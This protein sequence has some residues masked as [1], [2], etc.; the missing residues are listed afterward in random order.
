MAPRVLVVEDELALQVILRDN[1]EFENYEVLLADTGERGLELASQGKADLILLDIMLPSMSGYDVC[2]K[3]RA[4]GFDIPIV[5]LTARNTALD[6]IAGLD[7]GA[8]DYIGKPFN[9]GELMARVRA[10]LRRYESAHRQHK[11][12]PV[13]FGEITVDLEHR[14]VSR[15][16]QRL[17]LSDREFEL[18]RYFILHHGEVVTREQLLNDVWGYESGALSR[19]VDNFI[20]KLRK[21]VEPNPHQPRHILTLH[22]AGYRFVQ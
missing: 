2:R 12:A 13:N 1:L 9:V 18:L 16:T 5:M 22:G 6:R 3:V 8:D 11:A 15:G 19:T 10:Q 20:A 7:L 17:A 14:K 4:A 21:H